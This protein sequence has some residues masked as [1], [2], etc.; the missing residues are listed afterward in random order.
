M[1]RDVARG[2]AL[3]AASFLVC[4][5]PLRAQGVGPN[6]VLP[7]IR[8]RTNL[9]I[10][11][12][13][14]QVPWTV[15]IHPAT[16]YVAIGQCLPVYI[17]LLDASGKDIPRGPSGM[18][19]SLADF[20]WTASGNAAVGKYD[21][22]NAWAV[23]ACPAAAV[24]STIHVMATYPS[25]SIAEKAKVPGLAFQSYI[26]LPVTPAHGTNSPAGCDNVLVTTTVAIAVPGGGAPPT[27]VGGGHSPST[28]PPVGSTAPATQPPSAP[29]G[30]AIPV[31]QPYLP[32]MQLAT[33]APT[34]VEPA[35]NSASGSAS[36]PAG[37]AYPPGGNSSGT[38]PANA[39]TP[40][41][42]PASNRYRIVA[43][44]FRVLHQTKDDVLSRDGHG[45]EVYGGFVVFSYDRRTSQL[46]DNPNL[47]R[48][49]VIGESGFDGQTFGSFGDINGVISH[50]RIRGGTASAGGGFAQNDVFPAVADPSK[51]YGAAYTDNTFPF[52]LFNGSLTDGQEAIVI[53]PSMW[54]AD[55]YRD[56]FAKWTNFE[57]TN[58]IQIWSDQGVQNAV[59]GTQLA[60]IS[61]AGSLETSFGPHLNSGNVFGIALVPVL[62]PLAFLNSGSND[63]PIGASMNGISGLGGLVAGPVLPRRAVVI[64]REIIEAALTRLATYNPATVAPS[65]FPIYNAPPVVLPPPPPGTLAIQLFESPQDDLQG[66]YI[67]Y[68]KVERVTPVVH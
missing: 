8:P 24:G 35:V 1:T 46:M 40:T 55:G 4:V 20:D 49:N 34:R 62:G 19:V 50:G 31:G 27:A 2:A 44:G 48:T 23:C 68:L 22:P 54:E 58:A 57:S 5:A 63:R 42:A 64:T 37:T 18:R 7:T 26:E 6:V 51:T 15:S 38:P 45:D 11:G 39:P 59:A 65:V 53:L 52:Q 47:R 61:P 3:L 12:G 14:M 16:N 17:D 36:P 43:T 28:N 60:V 56:G 66:M 41:N 13:G 9:Q 25:A 67:L 33:P 10:V 29:G 21:G 30:A 32:P